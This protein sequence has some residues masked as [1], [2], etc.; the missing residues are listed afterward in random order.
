M[1]P[2]R[3]SSL[4]PEVH[5]DFIEATRAGSHISE[6][7]AY[8]GIGERTAHAYLR[9]G[10][11][12]FLRGATTEDTDDPDW[13]YLHFQQ[14]FLDA[15]G[16]AK[17]EAVGIVRSVMRGNLKVGDVTVEVSAE[18]Q[19][20]AATWYLER[21]DPEQWGRVNRTGL[22]RS[23]EGEP[24]EAEPEVEE[25]RSKGVQLLDELAARRAAA[26]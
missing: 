20:R 4:T 13:S 15:K 9:R 10:S 1:P 18:L 5:K 17:V 3:P 2:G 23:I 26:G 14:S 7:A 16:K 12:A 11:E 6:A 19:F 25:L 8:A 24:E 21:S 22:G